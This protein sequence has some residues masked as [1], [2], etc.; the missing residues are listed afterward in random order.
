MI[1]PITDNDWKELIVAKQLLENPGIAAKLTNII[2]APIEKGFE[3]LP[4][5]WNEK[6]GEITRN[7]LL[8]SAEA[9]IYT[10]KDLPGAKSS[11]KWHKLGVAVSGGIGGF[12]GL[13]TLAIELP[14]STTIMLRSIAEIARSQG[15][16]LNNYETKLACLEVFAL[17]GRNNSDDA[18]ESG[19]YVIRTLLARSITEAS[20]FIASKGIIEEGAPILIKF[21]SKI[22]ERFSIQI[23]EKAA[24]QGIPL[25]GA[26]GGALINTVFIDHFQDMAKGHFIVRKLERTYG[27]ER[28]REF[29]ERIQ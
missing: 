9:A 22:A 23:T 7:A 16:S 24:A 13:A 21:I 11:N 10:V 6:I 29:Y 2:G 19:Y 15:E 27:K 26:A 3:K 18:T 28:I 14:V 4:K 25:I 17:G 12:F 20:E 8:K 1:K 5:N